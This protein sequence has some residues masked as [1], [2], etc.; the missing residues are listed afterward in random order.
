MESGAPYVQT[1]LGP[2]DPSEIGHTLM[3][4]HLVADWA[5]GTGRAPQLTNIEVVPQVVDCMEAAARVGVGTVVDVSTEMFALNPPL[6]KLAAEQTSVHIVVATGCYKPLAMPLPSWAYPPAEPEEIADHLIENCHK[7]VAGSGIR[8]GIIKIASDAG[9]PVHPV[10]ATIF[11]GAAMAQ[12]ATGLAITTHTSSPAEAEE[13]VEILGEAGAALTRVV[14]G[15]AG[16]RSGVGGF[17]LF[18]RLAKAGVGVG[19]DNF[20]I[21]RP[22]EDWAEM[23]LKMVEA[24]YI[25]NVI[26]SHDMTV[27]SRGMEG[28]YEK[29]TRKDVNFV[30][31]P[32]AD[33][34]PKTLTEGDFTL[35]HTRLL[36]LLRKGGLD[37]AAIDHMLV[38]NPRRIL[39]IDPSRYPNTPGFKAA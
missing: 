12:K 25:D 14:I 11:R 20:G 10:V 9:G 37:E 21:L 19:F 29:N 2:V 35:I 38:K 39:T 17:P 28:I 3:H 5:Y 36:P 33:K 8:P 16:L 31:L 26:L 34:I 4:E 13:Q 7:G 30:D 23:A 15:H 18:E 27:F 24:G 1:V 6:V 22:D 32:P